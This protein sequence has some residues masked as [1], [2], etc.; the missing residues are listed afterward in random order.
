MHFWIRIEWNQPDCGLIWL[1]RTHRLWVLSQTRNCHQ[2]FQP[3]AKG[4][5]RGNTLNLCNH[6]RTHNQMAALLTGLWV[7]AIPQKLKLLWDRMATSFT[8]PYPCYICHNLELN[9]GVGRV[10]T[11]K[12]SLAEHLVNVLFMFVNTGW[13]AHWYS[14]K[15]WLKIIFV[16][17]WL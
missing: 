10:A 17:G 3:A 9:E 5:L 13:I 7:R 4:R 1:I 15:Q 11:A 14:T 12:H 2:P 16:L 8:A 6:M